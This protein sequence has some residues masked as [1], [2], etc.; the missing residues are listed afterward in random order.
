MSCVT[1]VRCIEEEIGLAD[2]DRLGVVVHSADRLGDSRDAEFRADA[3][4]DACDAGSDDY[5]TGGD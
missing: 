5:R 2:D 4:G 1:G 3:R